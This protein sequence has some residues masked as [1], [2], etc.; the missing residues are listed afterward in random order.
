MGTLLCYQLTSDDAAIVA[1][2]FR[3]GVELDDDW[4]LEQRRVFERGDWYV[5]SETVYHRPTKGEVASRIANL[6]GL[7]GMGTCLAKVSG[8]ES[9]LMVPHLGGSAP[10]GAKRAR[11][12]QRSRE[13]YCRPR[14]E[15]ER[16]LRQEL[17]PDDG[18]DAGTMVVT[19]NQREPDHD[20][21]DDGEARAPHHGAPQGDTASSES[22][23]PPVARTRRRGLI[24]PLPEEDRGGS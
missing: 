16:E 19:P 4:Q 11:I 12:I 8:T 21:R 15:V 5:N 9:V 20:A 18:D 13:Q 24:A 22:R 6:K 7:L 2:E 3:H 10:G 23:P 14:W 17:W 1:G